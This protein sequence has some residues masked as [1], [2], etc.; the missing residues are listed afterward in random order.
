MKTS[1]FCVLLFF[2]SFSFL[3]VGCCYF[4][5]VSCPD[6]NHCRFSGGSARLFGWKAAHIFTYPHLF[7]W[8]WEASS[9]LFLKCWT[10]ES[11]TV[12]EMTSM[13]LY[14]AHAPSV[15]FWRCW[16]GLCQ[17]FYCN[18]DK[19]HPLFSPHLPSQLF[20]CRGLLTWFPFHKFMLTI[21]NH[22][23]IFVW[24]EMISGSVHTFPSVGWTT[25]LAEKKPLW[26]EHSFQLMNISAPCTV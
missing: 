26:S 3:T 17:K 4:C 11:R 22:Y 19:Q 16:E 25:G 6:Y 7:M 24:L 10:S 23:L 15:C 21:H 14:L 18:Q 9:I 8:Y 13:S 2:F 5:D 1:M 12:S 20:C